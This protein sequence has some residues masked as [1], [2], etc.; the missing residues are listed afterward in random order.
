MRQIDYLQ[1]QCQYKSGTKEA[2]KRLWINVIY[3]K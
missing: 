1:S 3:P 2:K